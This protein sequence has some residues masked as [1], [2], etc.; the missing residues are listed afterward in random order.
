M[1]RKILAVLIV[2]SLMVNGFSV[3]AEGVSKN[4]SFGEIWISRFPRIAKVINV[5]LGE[6]ETELKIEFTEI[7]RKLSNYYISLYQ[8]GDNLDGKYIV[9]CL[10][11]ITTD[12]FTFTNLESNKTYKVSLTTANEY[13]SVHGNVWTK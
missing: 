1:K 13:D 8:F 10:G 3:F 2:L 11:P 9:K 4:N 7:S 12:S 6:N 5:T